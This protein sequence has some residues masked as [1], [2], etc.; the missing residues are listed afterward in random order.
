MPQIKAKLFSKRVQGLNVE[1]EVIASGTTYN[2]AQLVDLH[3]MRDNKVAKINAGINQREA[4]GVVLDG[5]SRVNVITE[6]TAWTLGLSWEP[7]AFNMRMADNTTLV[8][9]RITHNVKI[10][11]G[12]HSI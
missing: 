4:T 1:L 12:T 9:K 3:K 7:I 10:Q 5:G 11:L 8:P 2:M 6:D